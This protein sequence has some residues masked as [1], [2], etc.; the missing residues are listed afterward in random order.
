[1]V[2]KVEELVKTIQRLSPSEKEYVIG[3]V[4]RFMQ[5]ESEI[6]SLADLKARYPGEWLAVIIP[7][8]E[9]R[10]NPQ[11]GCLVAHSPDKSS[12]W[13]RVADLP[14]SEDVYLFFNGPVAAK[15]FGIIFHDTADT[16]V[17]ATVGD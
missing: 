6:Q 12:V 17:V 9:D 5:T 2:T 14:A 3:S 4:L 11:R 8:G 15:G 13:Q 1:M 7:E 16:P 10:Y